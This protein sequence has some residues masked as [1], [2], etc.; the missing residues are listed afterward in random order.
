[1]AGAT[2][3]IQDNTSFSDSFP[4]TSSFLNNGTLVMAF[5]GGTG[6][7]GVLFTNAGI[8][9]VQSGTL[10]LSGTWTN[11]SPSSQTLTGGTYLVT[12]TLQYLLGPDI[13]SNAANIVL[14][15]PTGQ[16]LDRSGN[17]ALGNLA[18]N[19]DAGSL[20]VQNG[21]NFATG[22]DLT[23]FGKV[24]IKSGSS[25]TTAGGYT[26]ALG[27]TVLGGGTLNAT[28]PVNVQSGILSGPG[29]INANVT[30]AGQINPG[31]VGSAGLLTINGN[32]TQTSTGVLTID[33]GGTQAGKFDEMAVTGSA[34]LAGTLKVNLINGF[35][36]S[37]GEDFHIMSF[38]SESGT[39]SQVHFP[40]VI[41]V[42]FA[43]VYGLTGLDVLTS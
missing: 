3:T 30:N 18:T 13:V 32:Y 12:D 36:P 39:F 27:A 25:F 16:I 28:N 2:F 10:A 11:L 22:S 40:N 24:N 21:Q 1:M 35:T 17:N 19:L 15:G 8:V 26:Q 37:K 31:G 42:N 41:G 34:T 14:D 6:T 9:K 20:T 33:L 43:L 23:N 7:I 4:H 5:P 38:A 29:T